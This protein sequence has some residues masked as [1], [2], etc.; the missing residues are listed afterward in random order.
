MIEA[1]TQLLEEGTAFAE[2]SH[3]V[4]RPEGRTAAPPKERHDV[5]VIG[6]G[7]AGLSVGY[8]LQ[9]QGVPFVILDANARI[10]DAWRNRW[11]SLKLFTPR[12]YD[13]LD[14]MPFPGA[15][16]DFPTKDEMA[17]YLESYARHFNLPVRT[18]TRVERLTRNGDD[19]LV[20]TA[21]REFRARHVVVAMSS[22]QRGR[23]P[24]FAAELNPAITQIHSEDYRRPAQLP[25]GEVLLVGAGNSGAEIAIDLARSGRHVCI[26]G[27]DV[28]QVPFPVQNAA[29]RRLLLPILFRVVFHRILTR[30]TPIG[31]RVRAKM[32]K[33]GMPLIRTRNQDLAAAGVTRVPRMAG[34]RDGYPVLEDGSVKRV[35]GIVW[36][37]G[38]DMAHSWIEP[39]VFD[40]DG[41]PVQERGIARG[42]PGLYFVGPHFLYAASSTMIHGIGRDAERVARRIAQR[43]SRSAM[44]SQ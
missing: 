4:S 19:Y 33:G 18:A 9:R 22:Y 38:F 17:D 15:A 11:D 32:I 21:E 44:A 3:T 43:T 8:H 42:E 20:K 5:I 29:A 23:T 14:G 1:A 12:R 37:T 35:A 16:N 27:R 26:S 36:C 39:P 41:E 30:D 6:G 10:G 28:G 2:L 40:S 25:P 34:V 31:R 13:S 24:A 7:Q